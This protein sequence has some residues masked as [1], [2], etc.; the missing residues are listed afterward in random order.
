M[1]DKLALLVGDVALTIA[2]LVVVSLLYPQEWSGAAK[3]VG[4]LVMFVLTF[5]GNLYVFELYDLRSQ[6]GAKTVYRLALTYIVTTVFLSMS[7]SLLRR[8]GGHRNVFLVA[9]PVLVGS[10]YIWR[11]VYAHAVHVFATGERILVIGSQ[12][13]AETVSRATNFNR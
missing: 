13:D 4:A 10:T 9:G 12:C 3:S 8:F 5:I 2:I 1:R 11:R 7:F 6:N